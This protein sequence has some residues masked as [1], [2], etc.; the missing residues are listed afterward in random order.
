MALGVRR[1]KACQ[2]FLFVATTYLS[3]KFGSHTFTHIV[4]RIDT[5]NFIR[6][7]MTF[8][9]FENAK[10]DSYFAGFWTADSS[11]HNL[12]KGDMICLTDVDR[13]HVALLLNAWVTLNSICT[14]F[15]AVPSESEVLSDL[16]RLRIPHV[17]SQRLLV[18]V[19]T[20]VREGAT[21]A[22]LAAP[23]RIK[24]EL[25]LQLLEAGFHTFITD[26]DVAHF[27][28]MPA[29]LTRLRK[30]GIMVDGFF[31]AYY[32]TSGEG[33]WQKMLCP[34]TNM[35]LL[36]N[37]GVASFWPSTAMVE[38]VKEAL[39][40]RA[41]E[42]WWQTNFVHQQISGTYEQHVADPMLYIGQGKHNTTMALTTA[43]LSSLSSDC[44][45]QRSGCTHFHA[46]GAGGSNHDFSYEEQLIHSRLRTNALKEAS[47][48]VL[49]AD[50]KLIPVQKSFHKYLSYLE[51]EVVKQ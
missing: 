7:P 9:K 32:G 12:V 13:G 16:Q 28:S 34:Q 5:L 42:G 21:P 10:R 17:F 36:T 40:F 43:I 46:I 35:S 19:E 45:S 51:D 20:E 15:L 2:L 25:V 50:W 22:Y 24:G 27:T 1:R 37:T 11:Y 38:L 18:E 33:R 8:V 4:S 47:F 29:V 30:D 49:R 31:S 39:A 44:L 14:Y 48:W 6:T 26:A 41:D 23:M 3:A